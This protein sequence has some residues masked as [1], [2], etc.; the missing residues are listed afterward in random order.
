M[1]L[2]LATNCV[3]NDSLKTHKWNRKWKLIIIKPDL[4]TDSKFNWQHCYSA[5]NSAWF[6]APVCSSSFHSQESYGTFLRKRQL[7]ASGACLCFFSYS[8]AF[9]PFLMLPPPILFA[10]AFEWR[11]ERNKLPLKFILLLLR[12]WI[13]RASQKRKSIKWW[14]PT[15][16]SK[17]ENVARNRW[18][19]CSVHVF[20]PWQ[21]QVLGCYNADIYRYWYC[22]YLFDFASARSVPLAVQ[23]FNFLFYET[24]FP[25]NFDNTFRRIFMDRS[26]PQF[27]FFFASWGPDIDKRKMFR[28]HNLLLIWQQQTS[29]GSKSH[30]CILDF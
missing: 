18:L 23:G 6:V 2:L 9:S 24:H 20:S 11:R 15:L 12:G 16:A 30:I 1:I 29:L 22:F 10:S 19:S 26:L 4:A 8:F 25:L 21:C 13:K 7:S 17:Y 3:I 14:Q 5:N 27:R 28:T